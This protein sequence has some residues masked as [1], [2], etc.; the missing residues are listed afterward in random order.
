MP[1]KYLNGLEMEELIDMDIRKVDSKVIKLWRIKAVLQVVTS[2][3]VVLAALGSLHFFAELTI[4]R[5]MIIVA[6]SLIFI[7]SI[8]FI[9]LLPDLKGKY[10]RYSFDNDR[11]MLKTGVWFRNKVTIP[12]IRIQNIESNVGPIAKKF[13]LTSLRITTASTTH[14]LPEINSQEALKLQK[15]IQQIIQK[16]I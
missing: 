9:F 6:L 12:M 3:I 8:F 15:W 11:I 7:S 4:P 13:N 2:S 10:W 16:T 14:K 5:W 1:L